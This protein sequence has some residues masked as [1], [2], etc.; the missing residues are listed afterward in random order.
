MLEDNIIAVEL[1]EDYYKVSLSRVAYWIKEKFMFRKK[2]KK[3]VKKAEPV[4][5]EGFLKRR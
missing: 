3:P 2:D 4:K 5:A 1:G